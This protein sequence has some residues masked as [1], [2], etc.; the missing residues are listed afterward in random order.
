M[1]SDRFEISN[2][3]HF[4]VLHFG[5]DFNISYM[6]R[7]QKSFFFIF[8]NKFT[9]VDRRILHYEL[10]RMCFPNLFSLQDMKLQNSLWNKYGESLEER[11]LTICS[12]TDYINVNYQHIVCPDAETA[13]VC[14]NHTEFTCVSV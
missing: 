5:K 14:I 12:G 2:K 6:Q 8:Y 10:N 7:V 11:S 4:Q 3:S 9:P 1:K 13:K